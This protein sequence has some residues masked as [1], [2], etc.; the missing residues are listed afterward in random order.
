MGRDKIRLIRDFT[1]IGFDVLI[2]DID[3]AWLRD[4]VPFFRQFPGADMLV[5]TDQ[6][7]SETA[8][9]DDQ[10][11]FMK[12]GI[13]KNIA[14]PEGL[15]FHVCH[16]S[17]NIG[18]MWFRSTSG[19]RNLTDTWVKLIEED[20]KLWDQNAF[21]DLVR[22]GKT[23]AGRSDPTGS[24]LYKAWDDQITIGKCWG[25]PKSRHTIYGLS[26]TV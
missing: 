19:S 4:P 15:E 5:S 24:G 13:A 21:N 11:N 16:A 14:R 1:L 6:L 23:C 20:D 18:M 8:M 7:R 26:V 17:L 10:V 2:S 22:A 12:N 3:V 25:F 9:N